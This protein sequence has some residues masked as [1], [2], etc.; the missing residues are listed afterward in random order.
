M[1]GFIAFL[2]NSSMISALSQI[3]PIHTYP[4]SLLQILIPSIY[5]QVFKVASF[6]QIL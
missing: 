4:N 3:N 6:L 5:A 1:Q 2:T